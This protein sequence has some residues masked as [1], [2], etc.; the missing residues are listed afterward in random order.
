MDFA[1]FYDD[2]MK[3][4]QVPDSGALVEK[5]KQQIEQRMKETQR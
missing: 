5:V 2:L 3:N 4:Q 1:N